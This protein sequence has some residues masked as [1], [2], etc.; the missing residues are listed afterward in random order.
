MLSPR[1]N[2][3]ARPAFTLI[4]LLVAIGVMAILTG[5]LLSAVQRVR[6][7]A[8]RARCQNNVRQLALALHQYHDANN[9]FPPG[10][11][12]LSLFNSGRMPLSGWTLSI[13]PFL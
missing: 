10:H 4:E 5:L 12:P 2:R 9:G 1:R 3:D 7:A 13:L 11:R 8:A 6:E